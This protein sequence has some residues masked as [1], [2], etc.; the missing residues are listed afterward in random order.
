MYG[1][2]IVMTAILTLFTPLAAET[3]VYLLIALRAAEG[4]F[5]VH[6]LFVQVHVLVL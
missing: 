6:T 4:F 3:S 5:E 2:G 1:I